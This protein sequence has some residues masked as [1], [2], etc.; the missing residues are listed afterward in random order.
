MPSLLTAQ[1]SF[2]KGTGAAKSSIKVSRKD[3]TNG[4]F[5]DYFESVQKLLWWSDLS[6]SS[7]PSVED[8]VITHY[9]EGTA[10]VRL[11]VTSATDDAGYNFTFTSP[12]AV[13]L[14]ERDKFKDE[15]TAILS[16]NR[17]RLA[18]PAIHAPG[19]PSGPVQ[20]HTP[21]AIPSPLRPS[22]TTRKVSTSRAASVASD[23]RES[24]TPA[25]DP[26]S[27]F[28]LRK[29]VLLERVLE[30][31]EHLLLA[32]AAA[33]S[34]K[35]GKPGQLVDPRPQ[36]VDGEIKIIITPQLVH[37]I[38][39]EYPVVAK[40]YNDNVPDKLSEGDFWRRYFQSKLFN[41]HR[42]SIR[43]SAAQHV[44][45]DDPIFDKYLEKEDDEL[46]PRRLREEGVDIFIDLGATQ[47]DHDETGNEKD[48]TMQA[49]KQRAVLPLIRKFNEHSG[50][51]LNTTLGE[52]AA[53]RRRIEAEE[54]VD[55]YAQLDL[56]D[57]HDN[58]MS[59][60]I[61]LNM[62]DRQRYFEGRTSDVAA[63][64]AG[65]H[66]D[67]QTALREA[68]HSMQGW[69]TKFT[70]LKIDKKAG[71]AAL[72]GMT[73]NVSTRLD[74]RMRKHDIPEGLF[75]QMTTCQTAANEFLRQFWLA[76]Y[77]PATEVQTLSVSTPAQKAV[78]AAK[79]AGYL[80]KTHEK[81]DAIVRA[82][83]QEGVDPSRVQ[84]ALKPITDAVDKA[85][86][87]W[88]TRTKYS[89]PNIHLH[90][91]PEH[92]VLIQRD[93]LDVALFPVACAM[94]PRLSRIAWQTLPYVDCS[95]LTDVGGE[96][97]SSKMPPS[98]DPACAIQEVPAPSHSQS[99]VGPRQR[100]MRS[101]NSD[102]IV[103]VPHLSSMQ[104][105][106][107]YGEKD[108]ASATNGD[109]E[110]PLPTVV[111]LSKKRYIFTWLED[112][113][114]IAYHIL[115]VHWVLFSALLLSGILISSISIGW[116]LR[117][118]TFNIADVDSSDTAAI[119]LSANLVDVD[120]SA[121]QMTLDWNVEYRCDPSDCPDVNIYFDANLLRTDSSSPTIP[122]NSK[123]DPVF[124]VIGSNVL[125]LNNGSDRRPS[126]LTF[127]TDVA[128]TNAD[129]RRTLQDYPYDIILR[130]GLL[131]LGGEAQSGI[132]EKVIECSG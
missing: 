112:R 21:A 69:S 8:L 56:E 66:V 26:T 2:K 79:M 19:T 95:Y 74:V 24:G 5:R 77:P 105:Y 51:L 106:A 15:L 102:A 88:R 75:R 100:P 65:P 42:A 9:K 3:V 28:R 127:R 90:V 64:I 111:K 59:A 63:S 94:R 130:R 67:F 85:L 33:E 23:S 103:V 60:G 39:E 25:S 36:T 17:S 78:K 20:A 107:S 92:N 91:F 29:K 45:K 35:R 115:K 12:Q 87:F 27:D 116:A 84:I 122:S 131:E 113:Y 57:L 46:E 80:S 54:D 30:G 38:F 6:W 83:H 52:P 58:Q 110:M 32:Q 96:I 48:V 76:I 99:S 117:L 44:V 37:D 120:P 124:A 125:A 11:K 128:I 82:A 47:E 123:P 89:L 13:A 81:I 101:P 55:H 93:A 31:R 1:T 114:D 61:E 86:L 62:Q 22:L 126:S 129:T 108:H 43:S 14:A 53:K 7:Q 16:R 18:T 118:K 68:K 49:G 97:A 4:E 41:A 98:S 104:S 40:A 132:S 72:N 10:Q 119:R 71:D 121:Q 50:R 70:E 34:Q 73:H 109:V